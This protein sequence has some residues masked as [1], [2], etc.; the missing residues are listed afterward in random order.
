MK[1]PQTGRRSEDAKSTTGGGAGREEGKTI[2]EG[3]VV[4]SVGI[5]GGKMVPVALM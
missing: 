2:E 3:E 4:S 1:R 5:S